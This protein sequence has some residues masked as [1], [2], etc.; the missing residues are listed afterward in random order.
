MRS[1]VC[2][3]YARDEQDIL[4][5]FSISLSVVSFALSLTLCLCLA[6]CLSGSLSPFYLNNHIL[7][8]VYP[9]LLLQS[10]LPDECNAKLIYNYA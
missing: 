8:T 4:V 1:S 3:T 9:K 5:F 10:A 6:G 7:F 2:A